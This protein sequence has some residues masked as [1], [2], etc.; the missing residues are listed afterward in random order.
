[1]SARAKIKVA[2]SDYV[3]GGFVT[4]HGCG[5]RIDRGDRFLSV[6][7]GRLPICMSDERG[8]L[9]CAFVELTGGRLK[10]DCP[11]M[12]AEI[13]TGIDQGAK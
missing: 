8:G 1:V 3:C 12:L 7:Q 11:D 13:S 2:A 10:Y 6:R 5:A 9:R 4:G